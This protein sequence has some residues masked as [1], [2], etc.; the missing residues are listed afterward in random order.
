MASMADKFVSQYVVDE[1]LGEG[2]FG[3]VYRVHNQR[4]ED[5]ALKVLKPRPGLRSELLETEV[6][7]LARLAHPN[8]IQLYEF[9]P[10]AQAVKGLEE[11]GPGYV[12]ELVEGESLEALKGSGKFAELEKIFVQA[13]RGL[14]YLHRRHILHGDLKPSNLRLN[15]KGILKILDFGM[16]ARLGEPSRE[17]AGTLD[18]LAPEALRGERSVRSDLFS[19]GVLFYEILTGKKPYD[20]ALDLTQ[21]FLAGAAPAREL[22]KKLPG[23]WSDILSR[24]IDPNPARRF[25]S[26]LAVLRAINQNVD[27]AY[28]IEDAPVE[29]SKIPFTGRTELLTASEAVLRDWSSERARFP[30]WIL[31]GSSGIGKSRLAEEMQWQGSL[32]GIE[33]ARLSP[34]KLEDGSPL[35]NKESP[36]TLIHFSDL[37]LASLQE[38]DSL[39]GFVAALKVRAPQLGVILEYN[40]DFA[41]A[42]LVKR[43][44]TLKDQVSA[45]DVRVEK[46]SSEESRWLIQEILFEG[47]VPEHVVQQLLQ[48]SHGNPTLLAATCRHLLAG[49]GLKSL[50]QKVSESDWEG[51][52]LPE[53]IQASLERQWRGLAASEQDLL[54]LSLLLREFFSPRGLEPLRELESEA[55]ASNLHQ[56]VRL[57]FLEQMDDRYRFRQPLY[58]RALLRL[59][60]E[61]TAAALS[62]KIFNLLRESK[63]T[64]PLLLSELAQQAGLQAEFIQ[65]GIQAAEA[66]LEAGQP[67]RAIRLY[68]EVLAAGPSQERQAYVYAYLASAYSRL[69]R[70]D[71]ALKAY[72]KWYALTSDDGSG[73]QTVKFHYLLGNLYLNWGKRSK[74]QEHFLKALDSGDSRR[75]EHHAPFHL[76]ALSLLG[77]SYEQEEKFEQARAAYDRGLLLGRADSAEKAQL[78]RNLGMLHQAQGERDKGRSLLEEALT[79][80]EAVNDEEGV[81][82]AAYVLAALAQREG[83]YDA[84]LKT[85]GRVLQMASQRQD[86]LKRGRTHSNMASVL[87]EIADYSHAEEN[88]QK[89]AGLLDQVG[90]DSDRMLNR[91]HLATIKTYLG[92]FQKASDPELTGI[93]RRTNQAGMM[94]Y[95]ERLKGEG[96]RLQR[97][98]QGA[99][100]AYLESRKAFQKASNAEEANATILYEVFT[101]CLAGDLAAAR[102]RLGEWSPTKSE[103]IEVFYRFARDLLGREEVPAAEQLREQV[104]AVLGSAQQEMVI[105]ALLGGSELLLRLKDQ[106]GAEYLRQRAFEWLDG[107]YRS[108]PEEMQLSFEHREDFSRLAESH[109]R[110]LKSTGIPRERFLTFARI[111]QRLNEESDV[112]SILAQVMDA[113]MA[114]AGADR[115]FLLIAEKKKGAQVVPGFRVETARNMK[116]ENLGDEEFKISLSVVTEAIRRRVTLLTDDARADPQFK[117]AESVHLYQLKSILVLPLLSETDCLGV[118]YLDHRFEIGAFSDE[119]LLFLKAFADQAVLAIEKARTLAQLAKANRS[120]THRVEE[121]AYQIEKMEAEL[122]EARKGLKFGYEEIIGHSPKMIQI[123]QLLDRITDTR[124]SVWI[125]GESGTGKELIAR[126]LHYNSDRKA[127]PFIAENCSAIPE[128]LLES[129]LFGHVKGAF[130]HAEKDRMGLF[131]AADGGTIFL[132]EIGD[133]PMP[134]QAKLLRV[135]QEGEVRRV[136]ANQSVKIDVRVVSATNKNLPEMVKRGEFREDLFFRLNGLK[137]NLPPLRER[138][139]DIPPLVQHFIQKVAKENE[140]KPCAI[141]ESALKALADYDWPG[142]IRELENALRNAVI[143]SDGKT[144]TSDSLVFKPELFI[145]PGARVKAGVPAAGREESRAMPLNAEREAILDALVKASYHKGQAAEELKVTPRHLYNLLEKYELPKNKWA[146]KRLVEQ[147]RGQ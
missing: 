111:N 92:H 64:R 99:L 97:D 13:L 102:E 104:Q 120:L 10:Q 36:K 83:R 59:Y 50:G 25:S 96:L 1:L 115:G 118:L 91:F 75:H 125:H 85:Y 84:A 121:Q 128:N 105:L 132:D 113:A 68:Q 11:K 144:I 2:A 35:L 15:K 45:Q 112:R 137:I 52:R 61:N 6:R 101:E 12:M 30:V 18:Y 136:G 71:E 34:E 66:L 8:L 5:F 46:F 23:Y 107:L 122:Q 131:E 123:L 134:M 145:P 19:L 60:G 87:I 109:R 119:A 147:E 100:D 17:I 51:I 39:A 27:E 29:V 41:E 110:K 142:N 49:G 7:V 42:E 133:M 33:A 63:E 44:E 114:L 141:S 47:A 130:T 77:K 90:S 3:R 106:A 103:P 48:V 14:Q 80:S 70:F 65:Y 88:A 89:A 81:V 117:H 54:I 57:Q 4:A 74:A 32:L 73:I 93:V 140:L 86:P 28:E 116:K 72:E 53:T 95:I 37:H 143:F 124:V 21:R 129:V 62:K 16:A 135:L 127:K 26:A 22:Q 20:P 108:L 38:V 79:M 67:E 78:L 98:Y 146:L 9:L 58:R 82:N 138:K 94:G 139:E 43:L 55:L 24:L 40:E 126:A 31:H 76:R 56:L 69:S